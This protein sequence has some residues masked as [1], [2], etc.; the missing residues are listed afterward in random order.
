MARYR[1]T[2]P[3]W[4]AEMENRLFHSMI[5]DAL[6]EADVMGEWIT[7]HVLKGNEFNDL[8]IEYNTAFKYHRI[9]DRV[10]CHTFKFQ[11][12]RDLRPIAEAL[13]DIAGEPTT[14]DGMTALKHI[15]DGGGA[16]RTSGQT[17]VRV[18]QLIGSR[19]PRFVTRVGQSL[20]GHLSLVTFNAAD[21]AATDWVLVP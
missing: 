21:I 12:N 18:D 11:P 3:Y 19:I 4:A 9:R 13:L 20:G 17:T 7:K 8:V 6:M 15:M 5:R 14:V 16:Y 2:F 10:T 1:L